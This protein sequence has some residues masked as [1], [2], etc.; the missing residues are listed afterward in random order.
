MHLNRH[1]STTKRS[2]IVLSTLLAATLASPVMADGLSGSGE[3]GYSD[4]DGNTVSTSLYGSLKAKYTQPVYEVKTLIEANYKSENDIQTQERYLLDAQMNRFYNEAHNYYSFV[5]ARFEKSKFE[6]V[7][8]DATYT[9]G[10]GKELYKTTSTQFLVELGV[11]YQTIDYSDD[12]GNGS[13]DQ[14]I[15]RF[16]A[17][18]THKLTQYADFSQDVTA[19]FGEANTK[20][21]ANTA[22]KV[23]MAEKLRLSVGYKYRHNSD[24]A[25]GALKL[26]TQTLVTLVYDF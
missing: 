21:E 17:E 16:K 11:G 26:D 2:G 18:V 3:L 5:G 4:S 6:G 9:L 13:E 25:D 20:T 23:K 19:T 14:V 7:D 8:L 15:G 1:N 22:V 10:L 12:F 24:P